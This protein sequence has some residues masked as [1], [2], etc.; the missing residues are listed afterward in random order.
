MSSK[1][2]PNFDIQSRA[3]LQLNSDNLGA[4][5]ER[6]QITIPAFDLSMR[7][8]GI[9]HFGPGHFSSGH[10]GV[11]A[12][13]LMEKGHMDCG[14]IAI[15]PH[16]SRNAHQRRALLASQNFL[17]TVSERDQSRESSR[18]IS[19]LMDVMIGPDDREA[20]Y[21]TLA[22]PDTKLVTMTVTQTAY[23]YNPEIENIPDHVAHYVV[24]GQFRRY[25]RG[26]PPF[27]IMSCDN[28]RSN[29]STFMAVA[30]VIADEYG[31]DFKKWFLESTQTHNTMVDR[32]VPGITK[33]HKDRIAQ[34][35][36]VV[37]GW[38]IATEPHRELV[39]GVNNG[40][41]KPPF[42]FDKVGAFYTSNVD[43]YELKKIRGFNGAH[44]AI[45]CMGRINGYTY[46]EEAMENPGIYDYVS[47]FVV[48]ALSTID[49][50]SEEEIE[51][52]RE[53]TLNRLQNPEPRD[54]LVR[55]V[56]NA[57]QE[58]LEPRVLQALTKA[59]HSDLPREALL[60][61]LSSYVLYL[62]GA[63]PHHNELLTKDTDR[64]Y[65]ISDKSA[66]ETGYVTVARS[67]NGDLSPIFS[68]PAFA[69]LRS[70]PD[71]GNTFAQE[72]QA[73]YSKVKASLGLQDN[74]LKSDWGNG[75]T[76]YHHP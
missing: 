65:Y 50:L 22:S 51:T 38:A 1:L 34:N 44:F 29:T 23:Q 63:D 16:Q 37:D 32:I 5:A 19:S 10:L 48:Q 41:P 4:I 18:V 61:A 13:E 20:V 73:S 24:E 26:L 31:K 14:I 54:E 57:S 47:N 40:G 43:D 74:G 75:T 11:Y 7:K 70:N 46:V 35:R 42:P 15:S 27:A 8:A 66:Y 59:Y 71:F 55:L 9:V 67:L 3:P 39:I 33:E 52:Y 56:R 30:S 58:K 17:Y 45:G 68:I 25:Q 21:E 72:F 64:G 76:G 62:H 12:H 69:A 49:A 28:T 6:N 36:G 60:D 53:Q 2:T